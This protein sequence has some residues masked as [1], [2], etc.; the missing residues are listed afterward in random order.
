M[1]GNEF[2]V[3]TSPFDTCSN[4]AGILIQQNNSPALKFHYMKRFILLLSVGILFSQFAL[5]AQ[6]IETELPNPSFE[7]WIDTLGYPQPEGWWDSHN[8]WGIPNNISDWGLK[9]TFL[10]VQDALFAVELGTKIGDVFGLDLFRKYIPGVVTNGTCSL[11]AALQLAD[12]VVMSH[13]EFITGGKEFQGMLDKFTGYYDYTPAA[14]GD[15]AYVYLKL[16][17]NDGTVVGEGTLFLDAATSDYTAFEV[18]IVYTVAEEADSLLIIISS[19]FNPTPDNVGSKLYVDNLA[20]EFAEEPNFI[21][22]YVDQTGIAIR[23]FPNPAT[24]SLFLENPY[25][26][27]VQVEIFNA[28]G[29]L[30]GQQ[31]MTPGLNEISVS[32][33]APGAHLYRMTTADKLIADGTFLIR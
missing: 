33:L 11:P 8:N 19:S 18:P 23:L 5:Q 32:E 15:S 20:F 16:W 31:W 29:Q 26:E 27:Q 22:S 4:S 25:T 24:S 1:W 28:M 13:S 21:D 6:T 30:V 9:K 12:E 3:L 10:N 17:K 2:G 7:D 14:G